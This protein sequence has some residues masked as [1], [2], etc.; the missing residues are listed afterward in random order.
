MLII[1]L[2][3]YLGYKSRLGDDLVLKIINGSTKFKL[4]IFFKVH[5]KDTRATMYSIV[6]KFMLLT[7]NAFNNNTFH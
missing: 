4:S 6:L 2:T 3:V 5:K 1:S 7:Y